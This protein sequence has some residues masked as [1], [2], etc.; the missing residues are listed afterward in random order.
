MG[1]FISALIIY[2]FVCSLVILLLIC[3][4][5]F[6]REEGIDNPELFDDVIDCVNQNERAGGKKVASGKPVIP[7]KKIKPAAGAKKAVAV[8]NQTTEG[9]NNARASGDSTAQGKRRS[10]GYDRR[11]LFYEKGPHIISEEQAKDVQ[12]RSIR[13]SQDTPGGPHIISE[14]QARDVQ[15]RSI[16]NSQETPGGSLYVPKRTSTPAGRRVTPTDLANN[17]KRDSKPYPL[18][19]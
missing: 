6:R 13:N 11:V 16:R 14:E 12:R 7:P 2:C 3:C 8:G 1:R 5:K 4:D 19:F 15:R 17:A 9:N 10:T 18:K